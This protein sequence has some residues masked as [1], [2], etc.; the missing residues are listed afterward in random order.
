MEKFYSKIYN[1]WF[2]I[3]EKWEELEEDQKRLLS[4]FIDHGWS[5]KLILWSFEMHMRKRKAKEE[6]TPPSGH[7]YR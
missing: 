4:Y 7:P 2:T 5:K 1:E 3:P 6:G